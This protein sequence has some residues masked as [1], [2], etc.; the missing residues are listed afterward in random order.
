MEVNNNEDDE[1]I[2]IVEVRKK[3]DV[4]GMIDDKS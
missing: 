4:E 1:E 2:E 3:G